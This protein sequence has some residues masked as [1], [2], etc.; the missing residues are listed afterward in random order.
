MALVAVA[1]GVHSSLD[2]T[3]FVPAVAITGLFCAGWVAGRGAIGGGDSSARVPTLEAVRPAVPRGPSLYGRLGIALGILAAAVLGAIAVT[4]PWR[5]Q[6]KG[7][8]A[9]R[10][11]ANGDYAQAREAAERARDLNPLSVEPYFDLAAVAD[12]SGHRRTAVRSLERAVQVEPASADAWRRLGEYYL[13]ELSQPERAL[14]ILRGALFLDPLSAETRG[15]LV[16][17]LRASAIQQAEALMES[18][19]GG[20]RSP[21]P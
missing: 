4:Q 5:A 6:E 10:L 3:W 14:P 19:R 8:E 2:W 12:A 18:R 7:Y 13:A 1:F 20:R 11:V 17:A 15:Q 21:P 16:A 9:L